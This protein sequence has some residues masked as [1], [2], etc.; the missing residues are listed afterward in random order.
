MISVAL[1]SSSANM[2][3]KSKN[4]TIVNINV[5]SIVINIVYTIKDSVIY[6]WTENN[7]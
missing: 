3:N 1:E 6:K 4:C 2:K 7:T 5:S